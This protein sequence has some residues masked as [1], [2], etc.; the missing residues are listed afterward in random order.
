MALPNAK[1]GSFFQSSALPGPNEFVP[2]DGLELLVLELLVL[3]LLVLE[4]LEPVVVVADEWPLG[5]MSLPPALH[6]LP[7]GQPA[8][9]SGSTIVSGSASAYRK[10]LRLSGFWADP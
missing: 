10:R 2:A 5:T 6:F 4:L 1:A 9:P 8:C 3:E 7:T